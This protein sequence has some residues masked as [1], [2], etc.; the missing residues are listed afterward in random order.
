MKL[1]R[2]LTAGM[3]AG[4]L[5]VAP[6]AI[7]DDAQHVEAAG[8][9]MSWATLRQIVIEDSDAVFY[10][11]D[12]ESYGGVLE[13]LVAEYAAQE[14]VSF[15]DFLRL[16]T[17]RG[18]GTNG[19]DNGE[20]PMYDGDLPFGVKAVT[21][22]SLPAPNTFNV[23]FSIVRDE[24]TDTGEVLPAPEADEG[25]IL[26]E[27]TPDEGAI[28]P[29]PTPEEGEVLPEPSDPVIEPEEDSPTVQSAPVE[30]PVSTDVQDA[31]PV[32]PSSE[33]GLSTVAG[34]GAAANTAA[35]R[36]ATA[37]TVNVGN[38]AARVAANAAA[39]T[40]GEAPAEAPANAK[41]ALPVTGTNKEPAAAAMK[42]KPADPVATTGA[43][44]SNTGLKSAGL[45]A[46][47]VAV[48]AGMAAIFRRK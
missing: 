2:T 23:R 8:T 19:Y 41:P 21:I 33:M 31:E 47:F 13:A 25:A 32:N 12:E 11:E 36:N 24:K 3:I 15:E 20:F 45:V 18:D 27:P 29:E 17:L 35:A 6:A 48:G 30:Q 42:S 28:L 9:E 26:P 22:A 37:P 7:A 44:S 38:A 39:S 5:C 16:V 34:A 40:A 14:S 4:L 1:R 10:I 46:A 43:T